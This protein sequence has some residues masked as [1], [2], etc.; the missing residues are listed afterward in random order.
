MSASIKRRTETNLPPEPHVVAEIEGVFGL[1][2][3][4]PCG[5]VLQYSAKL[6]RGF[7]NCSDVYESFC[8]GWAFTKPSNNCKLGQYGR[9]LWEV[10]Q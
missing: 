10:G 4:R 8:F 7:W 1:K 2:A 3:I 6:A 9:V 5:T